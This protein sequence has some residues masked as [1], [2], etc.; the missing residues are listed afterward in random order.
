M[1]GR[2]RGRQVTAKLILAEISHQFGLYKVSV[3]GKNLLIWGSVIFYPRHAASSAYSPLLLC[4]H[5][6]IEVRFLPS[7]SSAPGIQFDRTASLSLLNPR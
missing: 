1:W 3:P 7:S 2:S 6:N 4:L 5:S